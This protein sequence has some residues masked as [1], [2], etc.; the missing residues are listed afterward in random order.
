MASPKTRTSG[1][2]YLRYS[3]KEYVLLEGHFKRNLGQRKRNSN[4]DE[5]L[6]KQNVTVG[7]KSS[8]SIYS[9]LS[10][11]IISIIILF[12]SFSFFSLFLTKY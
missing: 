3:F 5:V 12:S 8:L 7:I 1:D 2:L 4:L 11:S 10:L 9:C 6:I